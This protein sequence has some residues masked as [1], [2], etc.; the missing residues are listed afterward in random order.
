LKHYR[1][2][3]GIRVPIFKNLGIIVI[4]RV[5]ENITGMLSDAITALMVYGSSQGWGKDLDRIVYEI[6]PV[7]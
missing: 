3:F 1:V 2:R 5:P 6:E 7:N 4:K